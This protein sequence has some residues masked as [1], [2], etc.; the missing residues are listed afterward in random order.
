[1]REVEVVG[2]ELLE[3]V[4]RAACVG[5]RHVVAAAGRLV[6]RAAVPAAAVG[7]DARRQARVAVGIGIRRVRGADQLVGVDQILRR[8]HARSSALRG[9]GIVL[10]LHV[11]RLLAAH[12]IDGLRV[13][14]A[15]VALEIGAVIVGQ[16]IAQ[17]G[18]R[19]DFVG[20]GGR[21]LPALRIVIRI[22]Q[23][24]SSVEQH[25]GLDGQGGAQREAAVAVVERTPVDGQLV[26]ASVD[27]RNDVFHHLVVLGAG[28]ELPGRILRLDNGHATVHLDK[29]GV[30]IGPRH[31]RLSPV[32]A[33]RRQVPLVARTVGDRIAV[34]AHHVLALAAGRVV[35]EV[36]GR[37]DALVIVGIE[38]RQRIEIGVDDSLVEIGGI[39]LHEGL[40]RLVGGGGEEVAVE[41]REAVAD[42]RVERIAEIPQRT[43]RRLD[44]LARRVLVEARVEK[45]AASDTG[46]DKCRNERRLEY[47]SCFHGNVD[48]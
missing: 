25:A 8:R 44:R 31:V 29:L 42:R 36:V 39:A 12:G 24:R 22:V 15:V 48:D 1:M 20:C 7:H 6:D 47:G 11:A 23:R 21:P 16:R 41:H 33:Q 2:E 38:V 35:E 13:R 28:V 27:L 45:I 10:G 40:L 17:L 9:D 37:P 19:D 43:E 34:H 30:V 3:V 46:R 4:A 5:L 18:M 26:L 32:P 14:Q